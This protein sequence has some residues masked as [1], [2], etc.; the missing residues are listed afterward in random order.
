LAKFD[1]AALKKRITTTFE[2]PRDIM[3]DWPTIRMIGNEEIVLSNHKG[4]AEYNKEQVRIK[5]GVGPVK[6]LGSSLVIKEIGPDDI[7]V[8]GKIDA[9]VMLDR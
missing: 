7:V 3:L 6:I 9:V 8:V 1:R 4:I 5:T 2:L